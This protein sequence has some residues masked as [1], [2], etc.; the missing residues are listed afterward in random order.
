MQKYICTNENYYINIIHFIIGKKD[1]ILICK[2][3]LCDFHS[4]F[5]HLLIVI[6][7]LQVLVFFGFLFTYYFILVPLE[8]PVYQRERASRM[9]R[10]S[11][12]YISKMISELPLQLSMPLL[13][14]S[15]VYFAVGLR[16][17]FQHF[18]VFCIIVLGL[19]FACNSFGMLVGAL[20]P[21]PIAA[22][23]TPSSLIIFLLTAGFY[24]LPENIPTWIA[25][26]VYPNPFYHAFR[27][28]I[29]NQFTDMDFYCKS[30][31]FIEYSETVTCSD[32]ERVLA[33][34]SLCPI[35]KGE[36]IIDKFDADDIPIWSEI[37]ILLAFVVF[38]RALVYLALRNTNPKEM[39][40]N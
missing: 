18:V 17:G 1:N 22:L 24:I 29:T 16:P 39:E 20:L 5:L 32:G 27:A 33:E 21:G 14:L 19:T 40:L 6:D 28:A 10:I 11:A 8:R 25:W 9:Y 31:Q 38:F 30:D 7:F 26:I 3:K 34:T 4:S 37:L 13:F 36:Q 2:L 12:Y 15:V 35:T 23:V